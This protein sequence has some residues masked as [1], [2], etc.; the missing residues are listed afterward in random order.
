MTAT[1]RRAGLLGLGVGAFGALLSLAPPVLHLEET[2]GLGA[3]FTVRGTV[4]PPAAVAIVGISA[5]SAAAVGQPAEL[6]EWSRSLH[7]ELIE[8]LTEL[9]AAVIVVDISFDQA[10]VP[11][12]D[13]RLASAMEKAGNVILLERVVSDVLDI[14]G[15]AASGTAVI[16]TRIA[17]LPQLKQAALGSAPF[18]LPVVP[19]RVSQFWTFGRPTGGMA[20]LPVVA[21]QAYLLPY[22]EDLVQAVAELDS[23]LATRLPRTQA[24]LMQ[25]GDLENVVRLLRDAFRRKPDLEAQILERLKTSGQSLSTTALASL[26]RVYA[27]PDSRYL[28]YYGPARAVTT[29]A[30]DEIL[31]SSSAYA[32]DI[33]DRVVF[34]GYSE[35]RQPV[36]QD[37]FYSIFSQRTGQ[38]LSGVEIGATALANLLDG[39]SIV[40]LAIPQHLAAVFIWGFFVGALFGLLSPLAG[41]AAAIA[42]A[43]GYAGAA[44]FTFGAARIWMP[45]LVPL[46]VQLPAAVLAGLI[47]HYGRSHVQRERIRTALGYYVPAHVANRLARETMGAGA[48]GELLHGTCLFTDAEQYTAVAEAM[49]PEALSAF[50][51]DYYQVM[52]HAVERHA[53]QIADLAGDSMVAIWTAAE[54]DPR[55]RIQ[56]CRAA[57]E[58]A[59]AV[60]DFNALR[61][62]QGLHTRIGL[63]TG[64]VFLGNIGAGARYEYR[65]VGDIVSTAARIQGLNR[66]LKTQVLV[67]DAALPSKSPFIA[68]DVGTFLLRGKSTPTRIHELLAVDERSASLLGKAQLGERFA[69][70]LEAFRQGRWHDASRAF[71]ALLATYPD[72]GPS[73]YYLSLCESYRDRPPVDWTG[74]IALSVK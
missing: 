39:S 5:D 73:G 21:L 3:L 56:A 1:L 23:E 17:P 66:L 72:D 44:Y 40:P 33:A 36:Q 53:G 50:M 71:S 47:W 32:H 30:Y 43:L 13:Q 60:R 31:R 19:I 38:N 62:R 65:A 49:H 28:N 67:S 55:C 42:A 20:S 29:I 6:D 45:T 8:R 37:V 22:Y 59:S 52:F 63:D 9:K 74:V 41:G 16:E 57:L 26:V 25:T 64:Q 14:G 69:A 51:N 35:T 54:A 46:V 18:T 68:R 58:V 61:G 15:S 10:R 24:E 4:D 34:V 27:G 2:A 48:G 12:D 7:A 11:E 70:A